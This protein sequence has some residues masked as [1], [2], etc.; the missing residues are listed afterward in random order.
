MCWPRRI[1]ENG[2]GYCR[3][4]DVILVPESV[5]TFDIRNS[6]SRSPILKFSI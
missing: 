1:G 2:L 5:T 3:L 4:S 6:R